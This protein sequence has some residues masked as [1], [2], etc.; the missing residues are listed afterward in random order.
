MG[1]KNCETSKG[2]RGQTIVR[3]FGRD[4]SSFTSGISDAKSKNGDAGGSPTNLGHSLSGASAV[5]TGT[6]KSG[7]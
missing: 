4:D 6:G 2:P 7:K 3:P 1:I 5:Q